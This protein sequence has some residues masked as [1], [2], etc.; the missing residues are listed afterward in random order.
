MRAVCRGAAGRA[1]RAR[2]QLLRAWRALAAGD[3]ADRPGACEP[4]CG[5]VDPQPVRGAE[6]GRSC[7]SGC[8][9]RRGRCGARSPRVRVPPRCRC[10]MRSGGCGSWSG[11]R[12]AR[13]RSP[14]AGPHAGG[15][16]VIPLAVR[17]TG[18]LDR[19]ALEGALCDLIERHE[20][21]R[22][23][24]P[25]VLGVP[26]QEV[27]AASAA[28]VELEVASVTEDEL[29][30]ALA[31]SGGPRV[32]SV[33]GS[34]R[35]GRISMRL[36]LRPAS[37]IRAR[38]AAGSASHRRRRLVAA[39]AVAGPGRAVPGARAR[40]RRP[41][42]PALPVQYADYTLWQQAVLGEEGEADSAIARQLA[43][44][45]EALGE[46]PEQIELPADRARPAV[47]SHR[48]GH[49]PLTIDAELHRGLADAGAVVGREPVHG[50]AGG[51]CGA[52]DAARRRDRHRARQPGRGADGRG[53]GR[54]G[55]VLR[56]H[57]GAAHRHVG[58]PGLRRADR[59][60]AQPEPCGLC[61]CGASV[62]ASGGGAQS[63]AVA[64]AASAVPGDAGV[65]GGGRGGGRA[66]RCRGSRCSRSGCGGDLEVRP[67]GR[68]HR[69]AH[70]VRASPPGSTACWNTPPT[71][72]IAAPS[73]PSGSA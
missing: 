2:R 39:S 22:T 57:A 37:G 26:R 23:V 71:C 70:G 49:V 43:F 32:R 38:A 67:V 47:S 31:S 53:A 4:G 50:A 60:G 20:S 10:P 52:A 64:V 68:A 30:A 66:R 24:F 14:A 13:G 21:L 6:R 12:R 69:A 55:R 9:R 19:A 48:G 29:A 15:T 65:R 28:R 63:G 36:K 42:L 5:G 8:R 41:Q 72:S 34:C 58:Q 56:Q 54:T 35:C 51:A 3:A 18:E 7:R 16:Y 33:R 44:W 40:E 11:W 62:R 46:L 45:K 73:R 61:A 17:L 27:V 59:P 1:G 25:E